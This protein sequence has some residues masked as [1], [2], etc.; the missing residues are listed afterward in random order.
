MWCQSRNKR[1][2][3]QEVAILEDRA[4]GMNTCHVLSGAPNGFL[5]NVLEC[6][7]TVNLQVTCSQPGS[8]DD[9]GETT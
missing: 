9:D 8:Q 6:M 2:I 4:S 3:R 7:H 5:S 1:R